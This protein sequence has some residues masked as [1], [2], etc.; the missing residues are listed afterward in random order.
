MGIIRLG[1][2]AAKPLVWLQSTLLNSSAGFQPEPVQHEYFNDLG[3]HFRVI[4]DKKCLPIQGHFFFPSLSDVDDGDFAV[5]AAQ[6]SHS[7]ILSEL[8][9][10]L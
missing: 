3:V 7:G 4:L 8:F 9:T 10:K 2:P 5:K 6:S 1:H